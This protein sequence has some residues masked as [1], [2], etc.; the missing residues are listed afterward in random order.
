MTQWTVEEDATLIILLCQKL[1][2]TEVGARMRKS[3]NA[4]IGR[5][6]RKGFPLRSGHH[7]GPFRG[8]AYTRQED[9]I[10][11]RSTRPA[12]DLGRNVDSVR[13][14]AMRLGG[15]QKPVARLKPAPVAAIA[16]PPAPVGAKTLAQLGSSDC[17]Y[18]Y[19]DPRDMDKFRYCGGPGYPYCNSHRFVVYRL[20]P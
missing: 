13:H 5:A 3:R 4:I 19:G 17:R 14:R 18:P 2:A 15:R 20:L 6:H 11:K 7:G 1:T 16:Y 12:A 9:D 8:R 10:I